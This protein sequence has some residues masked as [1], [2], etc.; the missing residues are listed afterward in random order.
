MSM[1][2]FSRPVVF[3][4]EMIHISLAVPGP[5]AVTLL[6]IMFLFHVPDDIKRAPE[7]PGHTNT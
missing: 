3:Q 2:I 1:L 6:Q 7:L 4:T 5:R